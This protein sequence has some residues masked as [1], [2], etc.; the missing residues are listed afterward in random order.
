M[1]WFEDEGRA[2]MERIEHSS[3]TIVGA[4]YGNEGGSKSRAMECANN[5]L[6]WKL[7]DTNAMLDLKLQGSTVHCHCAAA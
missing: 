4:F 6:V 3:F 1:A 7:E 2:R 5:A